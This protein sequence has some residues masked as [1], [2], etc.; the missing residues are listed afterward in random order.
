MERK[1][2]RA[3]G[4]KPTRDPKYESRRRARRRGVVTDA[5]DPFVVFTR[6]GWKCQSCKVKT[7]R[8]L[9]GLFADNAPELDHI[10]PISRGGEHTYRNTQL[11]CR[12]CNLNKGA[13]A[14]GQLNLF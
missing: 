7:P 12:R 5:V 11:L 3:R 4:W 13:R 2:A 9:R 10:V 6:D 1:R 8:K 14:A